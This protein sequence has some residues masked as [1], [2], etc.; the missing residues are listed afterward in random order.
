MMSRQVNSSKDQALMAKESA[1]VNNLPQADFQ[2]K[3][4]AHLLR[5]RIYYDRS[6]ASGPPHYK[7]V[8]KAQIGFKKI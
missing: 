8:P 7:T 5:L 4:I 1:S 2:A 3:P 6:P